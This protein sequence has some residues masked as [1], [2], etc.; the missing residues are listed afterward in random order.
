MKVL[1][2]TLRKVIEVDREKCLNC[3]AC[4]T[5]CPV[6]YCN[7]ASKD[8]VEINSDM[9]IGCGKCISGCTHDARKYIDDFDDFMRDIKNGVK[10]VAIAAP[11]VAANF[12]EKY[13]NLNGWL[14]N[15]GVEAVFDV[16]FGA[17]LTVKSYINYINNNNPKM[18]IAQPCPSIVNYIE[19]YKPELL[20]YLAPCDSPMLHIIKMIK[21][22]YPTYRNHKV[23]V[24][25]P[26]LAKR[27]EFDEIGVDCYNITYKSIDKY[28]KENNIELSRYP[29]V[30][31][32]NP[33]AERAVL[34][35]TPGG[36]MR[37]VER[38]NAE[39]AKSTRKIE[40]THTIY[41]YLD[42]LPE[43]IKQGHAPVLLDCLN[44]EMGCNGGS[45]TLN[46][47]KS[48]DE[49]ENRIE[50]R[51]K[52]MIDK[53]KKKGL[54]S[55]YRTKK[56][57]EKVLNKYWREGIYGRE[58]MNLSHNNKIRKPSDREL[59]EIYESMGKRSYSD[60]YN[61][62]ACG[63]GNC[64]H[65]G[66]A[67]FNGLNKAE[68]CHFYKEILVVEEHKR[69]EKEAKKAKE[70]LEEVKIIK[71]RIEEKHKRNLE[72]TSNISATINE[73]ELT[74]EEVAKM[75]GNLLEVFQKQNED[76]K[77]LI[78]E[79]KESSK[80][81]DN[82]QEVAASIDS[83]AEQTNLLALNAEIEAARAGEAGRGFAVVAN[84]VKKLADNS[85]KEVEK[86]K[87]YTEDIKIIL[88]KIVNQVLEADKKFE[89]TSQLTSQVTAATEEISAATSDLNMEVTELVSQE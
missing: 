85:R 33:H 56:T 59:K 62:S 11:A 24:I 45:G 39:I 35:S 73:M 3:L 71:E 82:F 58:Y 46:Q 42:K 66:I 4:I 15:M 14:K 69:A 52:Q 54:F 75:A 29:E 72:M 80:I 43:M 37:T 47:D 83:I 19:V 74:N 67:I 25:S 61:C 12:P 31:Y 40:G 84:E 48:P 60:F 38:E 78:E 7:D 9:C 44:C 18:V 20:E 79:I 49:I 65:M 21:E 88:S 27:R 87:P 63:Y 22:Y 8:Y 5:V 17:E 89:E 68:N 70:A 10:M 81:A 57:L 16:S 2:K 51:N 55:K 6:K 77:K 28:L 34:F 30:D 64:K 36:L 76:F 26:C 23:A 32:D 13:L 41:E 53:Y 50:K 86:I 1:E